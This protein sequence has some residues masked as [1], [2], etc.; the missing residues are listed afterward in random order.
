MLSGIPFRPV[1]VGGRAPKQSSRSSGRP[2]P[3]PPLRQPQ[4]Q[5]GNLVQARPL[6]CNRKNNQNSKSSITTNNG[7]EAAK[8]CRR[9][10]SAPPATY[11]GFN[12]RQGTKSR[13]CHL[14]FRLTMLTTTTTTTA[15]KAATMMTKITL[16]LVLL[17][18]RAPLSSRTYHFRTRSSHRN[19]SPLYSKP[20]AEPRS[21]V[22]VTQQPRYQRLYR[23]LRRLNPNKRER[24]QRQNIRLWKERA[25][26][27]TLR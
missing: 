8:S 2:Q 26:A 18:G 25:E 14:A 17:L 23:H 22:E 6:H 20:H 11:R 7:E 24:R 15:T 13:N 12:S 19:A 5:R 9:P 21:P 10:S 4:A 27:R 16:T 1:N 3:G